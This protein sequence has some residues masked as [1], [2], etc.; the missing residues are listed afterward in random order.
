MRLISLSEAYLSEIVNLLRIA[1]VLK[2]FLLTAPASAHRFM[3]EKENTKLS[4]K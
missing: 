1:K 3:S 2:P 4:T